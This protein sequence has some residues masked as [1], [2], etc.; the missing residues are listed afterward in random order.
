M[1]TNEEFTS[2]YIEPDPKYLER[3]RGETVAAINRLVWTHGS[4]YS[5]VATRHADF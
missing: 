1:T 4:A 3:A 2:E 5:R